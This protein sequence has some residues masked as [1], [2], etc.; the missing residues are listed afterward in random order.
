VL[1]RAA[2]YLSDHG[3]IQGDFYADDTPTPAAC[4]FGAMALVAT[5]ERSDSDD[6]A[7]NPDPLLQAAA[8]W[9][10]TA[11]AR[12]YGMDLAEWNDQPGQCA[13]IVIDHMRRVADAWDAHPRPIACKAA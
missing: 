9:L 1:R 12:T 10:R 5:G 11:L 13:A 2:D 6:D 7:A 3:W 4:A 8:H